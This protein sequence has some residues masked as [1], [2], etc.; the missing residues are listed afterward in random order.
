M[1]PH[2]ID[3]FDCRPA[4]GIEEIACAGSPRQMGVDQGQ[5][6]RE[7]A[8]RSIREVILENDR[9][10]QIKP[11]WLPRGLC[12]AAGR[13]ISRRTVSRDTQRYCSRQYDRTLGIA[14]GAGLDSDH[15]WLTLFVEQNAQA[16]LRIPACTSIAL[17]PERT[18]F[19]EPVIIRNFDLPPETRPFNVLRRDR[20]ADRHASLSLTF[21]QLPGSHTG[22]NDRGLAISYNLGYPC[23]KSGCY[24]S[25]TLIVQEVLERCRTVDEAIDLIEQS[26]R[27]GGALLTLADETGRIAVVELTAQRVATRRPEQGALASTNHYLLDAT[28]PMDTAFAAHAWPWQRRSRQWIGIDSRTRHERAVQLLAG[29]SQWDFDGLISILADHGHEGKGSDM[30]ICRHPPPYETTF[31]AILLPVRRELLLAPGYACCHAFVRRPV[32]T[33]AA[34]SSGS[35]GT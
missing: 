33:P 21:P 10:D 27:S 35:C 7:Q 12:L 6:L 31:A 5:A 1:N 23:D 18:T 30:T 8:H 3:R 17:Q 25:I 2:S 24:V 26:P 9:I 15:I 4:D 29:R 22:I 20:P 19:N 34:G 14:E 32:S 28:Q 13:W 11:S 16:S